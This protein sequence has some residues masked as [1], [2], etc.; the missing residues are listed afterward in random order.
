MNKAPVLS[1][2]PMID[3]TDQHCRAFHRAISQSAWLYSEM[4]VDKAV[5]HG[6]RDKVLESSAAKDKVVLQLGGSDANTLSEAVKI[7]YDYG[8]HNINLNCG[9][10]SDRVQSGAFGAVL[11]KEP[12]RVQKIL[13]TMRRASP[14]KISIKCRIGVDNQ[15][16]EQEFPIFLQAVQ[17]SGVDEVIIHARKAW[18]DGLSPKE[19]REIPPLDYDFVQ[20]IREIFPQFAMGINGGVESLEQAQK[21]WGKGFQSVMIGRAAYHRPYDI[22]ASYD[23]IMNEKFTP[24]SR[25]E[26]VEDMQSYL[27]RQL[28]NGGKTHHVTRHMMGLFHGEAGG[29]KWR[30]YLSEHASKQGVEIF[31]NALN[32]MKN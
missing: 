32:F 29:R 22:L 6:V 4:I 15:N 3:W 20:K 21:F 13:A 19:N 9:C 2:A 7:A 23:G 10:P 26:I 14:A 31:E 11:M 12:Q 27:E 8:Y 25:E 5:I 24:K 18:L 28:S 1:V 16:S 17:D 30:Q